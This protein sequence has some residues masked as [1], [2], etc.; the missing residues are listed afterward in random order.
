MNQETR[1]FKVFDKNSGERVDVQGVNALTKMLEMTPEEFPTIYVT[2]GTFGHLVV[3]E[4]TP[5]RR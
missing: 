2:K 3:Y 4:Y 5:Q 1:Q